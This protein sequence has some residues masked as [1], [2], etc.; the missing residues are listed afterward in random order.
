MNETLSCLSRNTYTTVGQSD[1]KYMYIK[2]RTNN[3]LG[4]MLEPYRYFFE[5]QNMAYIFWVESTVLFMESNTWYETQDKLGV[6]M[7]EWGVV[8]EHLTERIKY[9]W[10]YDNSMGPTHSIFPVQKIKDQML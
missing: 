5:A 2:T 8:S 7:W 1:I 3:V 9:V 4:T 6:N 10:S